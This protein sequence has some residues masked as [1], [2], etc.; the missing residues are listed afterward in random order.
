MMMTPTD[1]RQQLLAEVAA[2]VLDLLACNCAGPC[3]GTCTYAKAKRALAP[4][5]GEAPTLTVS[6]GAQRELERIAATLPA[7]AASEPATLPNLQGWTVLRIWKGAVYL[8]IPY[9]YRR[10]IERINGCSCRCT[11]C[12]SHPAETPAWDTLG[13][14]LTAGGYSW[15]VHAPEWRSWDKPRD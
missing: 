4:A 13:V 10:P 9:E 14:P 5:A 1:D 11:Y 7:A 6:A 12:A 2:E 15:T 8:R 3:E